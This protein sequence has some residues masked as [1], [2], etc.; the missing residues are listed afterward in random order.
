MDLF[1]ALTLVLIA[2]AIWIVVP[3]WIAA[4]RSRDSAGLRSGRKRP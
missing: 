2:T 3:Y 4:H 1:D